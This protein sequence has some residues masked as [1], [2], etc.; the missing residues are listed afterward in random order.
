MNEKFSEYLDMK[1]GIDC[2]I[3]VGILTVILP[4]HFILNKY[5]T[6]FNNNQTP[7]NLEVH[8]WAETAE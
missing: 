3:R 8:I 5:F 2:T 6:R 1:V 7:Y 4:R